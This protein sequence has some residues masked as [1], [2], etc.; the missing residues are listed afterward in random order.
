MK[1][2]ELRYMGGLSFIGKAGSN[3]WVAL[4]S[5]IEGLL[6]AA[7]TSPKE[8]LLLAVGGC[9]GMDMASL[10]N[11][12]RVPFR[13]LELT[14]AAEEA[15]EH[16]RVFTRI[17]LTYKI[18]GE[19][20]PVPEIERAIKMSQDKY[21]SVSAMVRKACP[22]HWTAELNGQKVLSGSGVGV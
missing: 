8:L 21:C 15:V 10:L 17:D 1:N 20:V 18:E 5:H 2:A 4:D 9:T 19:N 3:H 7:A 13:K 12:R 6:P 14:L 22:I 16:P 11:K